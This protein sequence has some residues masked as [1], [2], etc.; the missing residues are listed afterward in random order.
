MADTYTEVT[1]ESWFS[2]LRGAFKGIFFGFL[3]VLLG[4]WI[5]FKNEGRAVERYKTLKEG[6]KSVVSVGSDSIDAAFEGKLVHTSGL[7]ETSGFLTDED[8]AVTA[9]AVHLE[10]KVEMYQWRQSQERKTRKK[11]GGGTETVTTYSYSRSWSE[12]HLPSSSFKEPAGHQNPDPPPFASHTLTAPEVTLGA[13]RLS[14]GLISSMRGY[15]PLPVTSLGLLPAHLRQNAK[16]QG[17]GIYLGGNPAS[18]QVGDVR[19]NFRYVEPGTVSVVAAQRGGALEPYRASTGGTIELL[20]DDYVAA[21]GMIETAQEANRTLTWILR[22]LGFLL[23]WFG[24]KT[25]FK[26]LSVLADVVPAF[27]RLVA[28]GTGWVAFM[29]AACMSLC[30]IA[31]AWFYYRPGLTILLLAA[32]GVAVFAVARAFKKAGRSQAA[33]PPPP[34]PAAP[35]PPP[36]PV[37]AAGG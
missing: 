29:I 14:P 1:N 35:P 12:E 20:A 28:A 26:P 8:F 33:T 34:P 3:L 15:Q 10:R 31:L 7:A 2:R 36:P 23:V 32:A 24:L 5:L 16:L 37:P 9:N 25:I 19:I 17:G 21:D 30:I 27:G 22:G 6:G 18:P 13:F 11:L 4:F